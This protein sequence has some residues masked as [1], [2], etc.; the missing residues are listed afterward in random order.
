VSAVSRRGV[1]K[2]AAIAGAATAVPLG[3]AAMG[4]R[5]LVIYDSRLPAS[6]AFARSMPSA[7]RIDLA[8]PGDPRFAALRSG[9]P[10]GT[11]VEALTRRSDLI[12]LRH[13]LSRQ[14]LRL[15][16]QRAERGLFRWSMR[17]R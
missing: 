7:L 3:A 17:P 2:G 4:A 15:S 8:E 11:V 6:L 16:Q 13:E 1:L 10:K 12:D 5:R 14:G 9:L